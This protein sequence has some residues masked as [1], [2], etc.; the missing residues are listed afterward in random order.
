MSTRQC[1]RLR[2]AFRRARA[3][4]T[5]VIVL[6]GGRHYFSNGIH[7]NTIEAARDPAAE[8]WANIHAIDDLVLD[9]LETRSHLVVAAL[10]GN[11]GAGGAMMALA[12]D[13]V[14]RATASC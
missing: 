2:D 14:S 3:A 11:A 9:I 10:G 13:R 12:A 1:R 7:L 8:S 6:L 4:A 5:K